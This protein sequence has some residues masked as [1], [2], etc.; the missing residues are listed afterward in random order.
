M[1]LPFKAFAR[2][3]QNQVQRVRV[4][5]TV[6]D[7]SRK[8]VQKA[9]ADGLVPGLCF[10][11]LRLEDLG[12]V[13]RTLRAAPSTLKRPAF[14]APWVS[15][16]SSSFLCWEYF[17]TFERRKTDPLYLPHRALPVPGPLL[18]SFTPV[19]SCGAVSE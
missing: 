7:I 5:V 15:Q 11:P 10:L 12:L 4:L 17:G 16:I 2:S 6:E 3:K 19:C 8:C 1:I 13:A 9:V 14:T 18:G